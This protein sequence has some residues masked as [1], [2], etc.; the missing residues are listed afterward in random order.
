VAAGRRA[1]QQV[2]PERGRGCPERARGPGRGGVAPAA[3]RRRGTGLS[4]GGAGGLGSRQGGGRGEKGC[5]EG[6]APRRRGE[7]ASTGAVDA[8]RVASLRREVA[9]GSD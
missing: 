7:E 4:P 9:A 5:P 1:F 3:R 6:N 2:A 8:G